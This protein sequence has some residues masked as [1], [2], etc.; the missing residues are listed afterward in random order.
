MGQRFN[1][2]EER[3]MSGEELYQLLAEKM[4][5]IGNTSIDE[6]ADLESY[7]R[8]VWNALADDISAGIHLAFDMGD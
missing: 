2:I 6:F 5:Y 3:T 8:D 4:M 7:E 1:T